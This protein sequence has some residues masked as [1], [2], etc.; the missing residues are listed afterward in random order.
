[1]YILGIDPGFAKMGWGIVDENK[2]TLK[3]IDYGCFETKVGLAPSDRLY[4]LHSFLLSLLEKHPIDTLAIEE[5][6]FATNAK[7]AI[8]VGQARGAILLTAAQ[9]K[10][11]VAS[12][13]PLQI[14]QS[15][16]GYGQAEKRQI[17]V[18]VKAILNLPSLPQPDDAS[19]AL[20][21]AIT[22]AFSYKLLRKI[23]Q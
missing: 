7:T 10:I 22:H 1:M 21:V 6:Y 4:K 23:K 11:P 15:I 2:S 16:T 3:K 8:S 19:D 17:Q 18:L 14:K 9:A 20:A 13:T 12:Y 5:I